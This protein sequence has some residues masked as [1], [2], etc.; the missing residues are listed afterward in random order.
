MVPIDQRLAWC[1]QFAGW[2]AE[3]KVEG[4]GKMSL[5]QVTYPVQFSV[6]YPDRPL[7]RVTTLLRIFA[8]I[9]IL[10]VLQV[11]SGATV[12]AAGGWG[13]SAHGSNARYVVI[14]A[15]GL[16]SWA[17]SNDPVPAE[18]PAMV[19]RLELGAPT[20]HRSRGRLSRAHG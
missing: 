6:D 4:R 2:R 3:L 11:V 17:R 13:Q 18:I 20:V 8:V 15:G 7:N 14:G 5:P 19:V 16:S 1:G 9:P 10:I 12:I